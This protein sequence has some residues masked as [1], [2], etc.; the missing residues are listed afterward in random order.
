MKV[1]NKILFAIA[2]SIS[3]TA[4]ASGETEIKAA[5]ECK[6]QLSPTAEVKT[7]LGDAEETELNQIGISGNY[8][9]K[10]AITIFGQQVTNIQITDEDGNKGYSF[11]IPNGDLKKFASSNNLKKDGSNRYI[12]QLKNGGLIEAGNVRKGE[13]QIA[14]IFGA[15]NE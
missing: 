15:D 8:T 9:L 11:I 6:K 4:F 2:L 12:K 7:T 13:L 5:F 3:S 10:T 14:C 1:T